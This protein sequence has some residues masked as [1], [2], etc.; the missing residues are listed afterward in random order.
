MHGSTGQ[1]IYIYISPQHVYY[2]FTVVTVKAERERDGD[3]K[4]EGHTECRR[5]RGDV[6]RTDGVL[7]EGGKTVGRGGGLSLCIEGRWGALK[8]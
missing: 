2:I 3:R 7:E 6:R 4:G 1:Y 8:L 5:R